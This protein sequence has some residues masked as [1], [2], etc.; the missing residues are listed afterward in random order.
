MGAFVP[1]LRPREI[2]RRG[3]APSWFP[4]LAAERSWIIFRR[5]VYVVKNTSQ[6][7]SVKNGRPIGAAILRA[8]SAC[9]F[10]RLDGFAVKARKSSFGVTTPNES[11]IFLP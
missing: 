4:A 5:G 7:A 9:S 3:R 1:V 10:I 6:A 11:F 2:P 8:R